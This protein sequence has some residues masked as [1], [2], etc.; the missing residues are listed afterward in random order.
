MVKSCGWG[1]GGGVAHGI[2]VTSLS[3][4]MDFPFF[5]SIFGIRDLDHI[6]FTKLNPSSAQAPKNYFLIKSLSS[7]PSESLSSQ[8][9]FSGSE[10]KLLGLFLRLRAQI[11]K[12]KKMHHKKL[13]LKITKINIGA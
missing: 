9:F 4:K 10:L 11:C 8:M 6:V 12:Y 2:L 13:E 1:F 3:P 7:T 5:S